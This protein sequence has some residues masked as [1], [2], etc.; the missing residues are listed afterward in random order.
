VGRGIHPSECAEERHHQVQD[1]PGVDGAPA[2]DKQGLDRGRQVVAAPSEGRAGQDHAGGSG[3]LAEQ[4][5][6]SEQQH[7]DEVPQD[8]HSD[9]VSKAESEVDAQG[10]QNPVDGRQVGSGP[11]PE[12]A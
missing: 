10:S 4:D 9:S 7:S 6:A 11:D 12:L 2:D 3:L 8:Q 1:D 5:E